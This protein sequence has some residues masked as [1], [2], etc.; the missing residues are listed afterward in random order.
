MI[1]KEEFLKAKAII[2][3][4]DEERELRDKVEIEANDRLSKDCNH[5]YEHTN[6]K[7]QSPHQQKCVFC[8]HVIN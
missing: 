5:H 6:F 7:W 3:Q 1:T 2:K 4:W 8:G